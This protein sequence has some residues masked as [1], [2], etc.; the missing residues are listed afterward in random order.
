MI[1]LK[2]DELLDW[3]TKSNR[4]P[5]ILN[6]ARQVGKSW[7]VKH[8][9]NTYFEGKLIVINFEIRKDLHFIFVKNLD[10]KRIVFELELA[11]NIKI[12]IGKD[13]VFFDEIQFC[14][15]A[16][17]SVR[18]FYEE[19]PELHLIAAGSLLDFEFRDVPFPVGRVDVMNLYPLNFQEFLMARQKEN[20]VNILK[21]P[22]EQF[23][24]RYIQYFEV[25]LT[26]YMIV[27][28]M[29]EAV[30][31]FVESND[32]EKVKYIQDTLLYTYEQ[33]FK[34]YRPVVNADCLDDIISNTVKLLGSQ[35][36]YS[37]LTEKFSNPTIKKGIEVLKTARILHSVQ[38]VSVSGLPL[39]SSG[40]QFKIYFIDI[41]LLLRKSGIDYT[42]LYL[43]RELTA[44]FKGTLAEQFVAQQLV[45][46]FNKEPNYW[47]RTESG[48]SSEVDFVI[49]QNGKIIPI[50]VKAGKSG[51]LK[52]L[53]YLLEHN[54]HI[55]EAIVYSNARFGKEGKINYLPL[56]LAGV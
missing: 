51:S 9:G 48:A 35:L 5:L 43:K 3:K 25:E 1:R 30:A 10:V 38:N 55:E 22:V 6:G 39:T 11:L 44:A 8:F 49:E 19:L 18:Y 41:G 37:K 13:L 28:G 42:S 16:L 26:L 29:P 40:K 31:N 33:D 21:A 45:S 27:G 2:L 53:H 14:T 34:K 4:K 20:L 24:E 23:D 36:I 7:L 15:N 32:L 56:I 50:E 12:N 54:P 46:K 47:A 17:S 52:S